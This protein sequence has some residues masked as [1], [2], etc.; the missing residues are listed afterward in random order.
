MRSLFVLSCQKIV[1]KMRLEDYLS[2]LYII[3]SRI[4]GC[5]IYFQGYESISSLMNLFSGLMNL[6]SSLMNLFQG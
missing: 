3:F 1:I 2:W 5:K 4:Y 6:F